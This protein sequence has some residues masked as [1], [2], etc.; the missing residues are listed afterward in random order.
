MINKLTCLIVLLSAFYSN[1]IAQDLQKGSLFDSDWKFYKGKLV[2]AEDPNFDDKTWRDIIIPHDWSIE[3]LPAANTTDKSHIISGPFDSKSISGKNS[4]FTVGGTGWY[5]KHFVLSESDKGKIVYINF[6]GVY[7]NSDVWINGHHLGNHPYGYTS[8]TYELS[9]SL[10]YGAKENVIAVEVKNEGVNSRWYSGSGIYR[11]VQLSIVDKI[12]IA[13]D[14]TFITTPS[15]DSLNS[16]VVVQVEINNETK[17]DTDIIFLVNIADENGNIVASNKASTRISPNISNHVQLSMQIHKPMLWSPETPY[18]YKA[19]CTVQTN[20][21][22]TDKTETAFGIRSLRFDTEKGLFLNG[23]HIKLKGGAMHSNNGPLGAAAFDRAEQRR[24]ELMKNA[25]FNT[26][27]CGHNPPSTVFLNACDRLGML[28]IDEAF[29]VWKFGWLPDDY[30]VYFKDWWQKDLTSMIKRDRNHPSIFTY[31]I[32]NQ[33]KNNYDSSVVALGY[34][35]AGFARSLDPTRPISANVAQF[36]G[37]W[38][39][40]KQEEW[41]S[42]DAF[43]AALDIV[44]YSY[45]SAQYEADH[46]RLP[47]RIMFSSEIDPLNSFRNWMRAIDHEFVLGN[48]EWTAWDFI[49][50]VS[51]GW[52]ARESFEAP[53]SVL[54][55]WMSTYSGDFDLCGFRKPRSYYRDVLFKNDNK[56]SCF[57]FSPTPSF[58]FKNDSPWGW[59]D[60]KQSWTWPG[61][62]G[63]NMDV[64][65]YSAC[66]SIQ[67]FLN[68]KLL[69]TKLTSRATEFKATWQVPYQKGTLKA[70]GFCKGMKTAEWQLTTAEKPAKI[71]LSADRT[72][73]KADG[74][75]LSY[76]TVE[77]TDKNGVLNP[78]ANNQIQFSVEGNGKIVGV[79]NSNPTSIESF[80]QP[81]RKAF[82]GK[83]LVIVQSGKQAGEIRL[84]ATSENL[85]SAEVIVKVEQK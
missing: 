16:K 53:D 85:K 15:V 76:I 23:K 57:V 39:D 66:D 24:V 18:L 80:Q 61:Y 58:K 81:T 73:I 30:H 27:R 83:C 34:K 21:P 48:S 47:D 50:E 45:Q 38:H 54:F 84:K 78:Q 19:I 25:G 32:C 52:A 41:R 10:N 36:K 37:G 55:P 14:G 5:R 79:G 7:M 59:D 65:A 3:D 40:C 71:H 31:S 12:H 44:G 35:V 72:T 26:I 2:G 75:D 51:L 67:L 77:I 6:D 64:V 74:L 1:A 11:H 29:D 62:E 42:C 9:K 60:V 68:N 33:V 63:K 43:I 69:G 13:P 4:G 20:G 22:V 17:K 28:V 56:L 82:E 46:K 49:G 70:V 8:F